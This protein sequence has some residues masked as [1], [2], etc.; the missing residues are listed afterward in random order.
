M[1]SLDNRNQNISSTVVLCDIIKTTEMNLIEAK[2]TA[3][4][5]LGLGSLSMGLLPV[6]FTRFSRNKY[7]LFLS[8]LLCF[9]AGV[10]LATS[11][12]HLLPEVRESLGKYSQYAE[13]LFCGGFFILYCID[14]IVHF[15][16]SGQHQHNH[17]DNE[18][19][20]LLRNSRR[21]STGG[22]YGTTKIETGL[23]H[24]P[25]YNPDYRNSENNLV[26]QQTPSASSHSCSHDVRQFN[27]SQICHIGHQEPCQ[28]PNTSSIS[29]IIALTVHAIL[30]GLAVGLEDS[31]SQV[32]EFF[33]IKYLNFP[34]TF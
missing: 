9:G 3:M 18:N 7:P 22:V 10:L 14:E 12:V 23:L 25:P 31:T 2:V 8:T 34:Q 16:K 11:M 24:Q 20:P 21:H 17:N 27:P 26:V 30:E 32:C 13:V 4:I 28:R 29:L 15:C 6:L 19:R 5:A 1:C 33:G